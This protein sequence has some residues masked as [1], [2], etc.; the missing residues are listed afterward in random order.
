MFCRAH[1]SGIYPVSR[2]KKES[3]KEI[4]EKNITRDRSFIKVSELHIFSTVGGLVHF[5]LI[6]QL[7]YARAP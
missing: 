5:A 7:V 3:A 1:V 2:L 6:V 4:P